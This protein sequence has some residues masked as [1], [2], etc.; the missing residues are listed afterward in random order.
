M[1]I[2]PTTIDIVRQTPVFLIRFAGGAYP[3]FRAADK[4]LIRNSGLMVECVRKARDTAA[5]EVPQFEAT[6]FAVIFINHPEISLMLLVAEL[7]YHRNVIVDNVISF[8]FV[9]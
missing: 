7:T 4:I 5:V 6:S 9:A 8:G 2:S 1:D 3:N